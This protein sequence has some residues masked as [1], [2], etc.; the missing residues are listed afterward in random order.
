MAR[1]VCI[2]M[3]GGVY[4]PGDPIRRSAVLLRDAAAGRLRAITFGTSG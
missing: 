2:A 1:P 3:P 4:G